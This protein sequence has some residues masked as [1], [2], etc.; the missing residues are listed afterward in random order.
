MIS[1]LKYI[2]ET[3]QISNVAFVKGFGS[4]RSWDLVFHLSSHLC[5]V[6][7]WFPP[8]SQYLIIPCQARSMVLINVGEILVKH[9]CLSCHLISIEN[10]LGRMLDIFSQK[11]YQISG[12]FSSPPNLA[13]LSYM[14]LVVASSQ[15]Q[16]GKQ[17][18]LKCIIL[19]KSFILYL[20]VYCWLNLSI[21]YCTAIW[22]D[23]SFY[24]YHKTTRL[25]GESFNW[26]VDLSY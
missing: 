15:L 18:I 23:I 26:Y 11:V 5:Q 19:V 14:S 2:L 3:P 7:S 4:K 1:K 22:P 16:M 24:V 8:I 10:I 6:S 17:R 21:F 12:Y 25:Q 20:F 9:S 13:M